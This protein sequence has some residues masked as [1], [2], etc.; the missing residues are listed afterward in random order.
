MKKSILSTFIILFSLNAVLNAEIAKPRF[1]NTESEQE[2]T[3]KY[4]ETP[5][6][7]RIANKE[8]PDIHITRS[9]AIKRGNNKGE[10]RYSLFTDTGSQKDDAKIQ[11]YVWSTMCLYNMCGFETP[12]GTLTPYGDNDVKGEF[13]GTCGFN[14]YVK[15]PKSKYAEGYNFLYIDFFYKE[16]QGL[17]VRT[18]LFEDTAFL[19]V[20]PDGKISADSAWANNFDSFMFI[21][22]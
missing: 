6:M 1:K 7:T 10:L 2:F 3:I 5:D 9:Y 19:G 22:K 13:N 20:T 11:T 12:K 15:N 21:D 16:N 14:A 4:I 8:N 18:F 17:V